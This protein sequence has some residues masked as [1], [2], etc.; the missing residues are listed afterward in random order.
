MIEDKITEQERLIHALD[1]VLKLAHDQADMLH[2]TGFTCADDIIAF[3]AIK[4]IKQ[5]KQKLID[6]PVLH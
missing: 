4:F 6:N 1:V 5:Y 3:D 2:M